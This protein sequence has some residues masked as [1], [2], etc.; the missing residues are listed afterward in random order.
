MSNAFFCQWLYDTAGL[1][2]SCAWWSLQCHRWG[3]SLPS[4]ARWK[5]RPAMAANPNIIRL[6]SASTTDALDFYFMKRVASFIGLISTVT[7]LRHVAILQEWISQRRSQ[8]HHAAFEKPMWKASDDVHSVSERRTLER[9]TPSIA[10]LQRPLRNPA[11][12]MC[13]LDH[14]CIYGRSF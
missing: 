6:T 8:T 2:V 11:A 1:A 7:Q 12:L 4:F 14:C 3:G 9:L 10:T 5:L 13:C